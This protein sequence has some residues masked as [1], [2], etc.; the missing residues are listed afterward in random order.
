MYIWVH[1]HMCDYTYVYTHSYTYV[2]LHTFMYIYV[3]S[4]ICTQFIY[5]YVSVQIYSLRQ[6]DQWPFL[7]GGEH[8]HH[9]GIDFP[10]FFELS[11]FFTTNIYFF[12]NNEKLI[13]SLKSSPKVYLWSYWRGLGPASPTRTSLI[14]AIFW[15][16]GSWEQADPGNALYFPP[17]PPPTV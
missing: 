5:I 9:Y 12:Y 6:C 15:A 10:F 13:L 16:K 1:I 3:R 4:H 7:G 2:W 14:H 17:P 8:W 11:H